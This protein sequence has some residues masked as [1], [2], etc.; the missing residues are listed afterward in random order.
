MLQTRNRHGARGQIIMLFAFSITLILLVVGLV[1]DG[2]NAL[3]QRRN[4]QNASDFAA[5]AGAR[6]VAEKIGGDTVN[7]TDSNV[8]AAIDRSIA[9][10]KG[11]PLTYGSPNGPQYVTSSG[12][13]VGFL[14]DSSTI[15][16]GAVGVKLGTS[17]VFHPFFLGII[18]MSTWTT[19]ASAT[20]KGGYSAGAPPGPVFPMGIAQ[21]F[22]D[23]RQP[24]AGDISATVGDLCYPAHLTAGSLNVPGGFGWLKFGCSGYGLGQGSS[25]GCTT[26][27][28]FLQDEIG[29][30]G[31]SYGC[32]TAIGL[33]GSPD[34]IGSLPGNKASADC[35]YY[36]T[37]HSMLTVAVWDSAGG[38]GSNAYYHVVGYTGFQITSCDGGKDIEGV[39]RV[40]IYVGPTT[41]TPGFAGAP[42]AVQLVR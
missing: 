40:P 34:F 14:G 28:P 12:A 42:L 15:P 37:N 11:A 9:V 21:A 29:P 24:C 39:W 4:A 25:G 32:C 1:V 26:S 38:T 3:V 33:P 2:G 18:G 8:R 23:G 6:V 31:N 30:P 7:G 35:N 19:S 27:K 5:L 10:N 16:T 22:F 13:T 20:A 36:I 41:T 17:R